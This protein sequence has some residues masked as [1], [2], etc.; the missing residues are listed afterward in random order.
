MISVFFLG[1]IFSF[2]GYTPPSVLNMTALKIRLQKDQRDFYLFTSGVL[3][4]VFIQAYISVYLT[5]YIANNPMLIAFLEKIG[6]VILILLSVYF[7]RLNRIEKKSVG[8]QHT[9]KNSFFTGMLL[10]TLN[11]FAIPFFCGIIAFLASNNLMDYS[12]LSLTFFLIGSVLGTF[13]I[14]FL[15]GKY[16]H[17]IQQKTGSLTSKINLLLSIVTFV[18]AVLTFLK[19]VI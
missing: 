2:V 9:I 19:F 3:L 6:I 7:Y 8:Y 1:L 16:A 15:Y 14:L 18:F 17:K 5:K 12:K 13:Y 4:I 11:M 10:S